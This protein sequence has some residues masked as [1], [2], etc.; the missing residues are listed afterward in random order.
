M[1]IESLTPTLVSTL[2]SGTHSGASGSPYASTRNWCF[3][4]PSTGEIAELKDLL[5]CTNNTVAP[6]ITSSYT[7]LQALS[8][9]SRDSVNSESTMSCKLDV[10]SPVQGKR[11]V[12]RLTEL[13]EITPPELRVHQPT[14]WM[15][16]Q[17]RHLCS[18]PAQATHSLHAR[19]CESAC[20]L[21]GCSCKE[22]SPISNS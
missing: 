3:T 5:K 10:W 18:S 22:E 20:L 11:A 12:A 6:S 14:R 4:A 19:C 1:Q 16:H 15:L 2:R 8:E 13:H 7:R 9:Q 21:L 17:A